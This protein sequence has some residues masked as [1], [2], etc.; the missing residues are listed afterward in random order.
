MLINYKINLKEC[1]LCSKLKT[2]KVT[3][4]IMLNSGRISY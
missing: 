3:E 1:V 4:D 2:S